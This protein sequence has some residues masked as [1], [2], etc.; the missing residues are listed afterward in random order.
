MEANF[1]E[2]LNNFLS[3]WQILFSENIEGLTEWIRLY[4]L[5]YQEDLMKKVDDY[6]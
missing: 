5:F 3:K 6:C 1:K 2:Q 4:H